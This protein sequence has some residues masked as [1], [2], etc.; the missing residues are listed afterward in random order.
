MLLF[1]SQYRMTEGVRDWNIQFSHAISM[2]SIPK[3][4]ELICFL[5]SYQLSEEDATIWRWIL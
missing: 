2:S 1:F 3:F 4:V 5:N